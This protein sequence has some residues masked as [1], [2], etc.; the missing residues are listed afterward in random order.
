[1]TDIDLDKVKSK[2]FEIGAPENLYFDTKATAP[3]D[4]DLKIR[5]KFFF[6]ILKMAANA[7]QGK[8]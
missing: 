6:S 1:M 4:A 3:C 5:R 8:I 7:D 2:I